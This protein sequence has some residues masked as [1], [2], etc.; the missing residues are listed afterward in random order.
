MGSRLGHTELDMQIDTLSEDIANMKQSKSKSG[1]AKD[2][3]FES[4]LLR[5]EERLANLEDKV[6]RILK[7]LE[8]N[9]D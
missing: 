5:K 9:K 3:I 8:G 7:A 2:K 6:D 1:T 4:Q